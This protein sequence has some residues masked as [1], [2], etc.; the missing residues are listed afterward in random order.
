VLKSRNIDDYIDAGILD[1][2]KRQG[3]FAEMERKYARR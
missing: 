3:F 2:L 1:G